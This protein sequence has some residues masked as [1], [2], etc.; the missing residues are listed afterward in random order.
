MRLNK[1]MSKD[2]QVMGVALSKRPLA[3]LKT[4]LMN[5]FGRG[6]FRIF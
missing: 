3:I 2:G 1:L 6:I 4:N 5:S